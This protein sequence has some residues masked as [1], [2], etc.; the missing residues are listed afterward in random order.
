MGKHG[1]YTPAKTRQ[2][3]AEIKYFLHKEKAPMLFGGIVLKLGFG[4]ERPK[5]VKENK[6]PHHTTK[7]D[8]DNLIKQFCDAANSILWPDDACIMECHAYKFYSERPCII[9]SAREYPHEKRVDER[10]GSI[11]DEDLL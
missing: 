6:R 5:S 11:F 10:L 4:F 7:P 9:V 8:L 1:A 3:S 2:S